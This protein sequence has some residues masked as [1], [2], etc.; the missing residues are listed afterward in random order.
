M[1]YLEKNGQD[2]VAFI[3]KVYGPDYDSGG[4]TLDAFS[5]VGRVRIAFDN[6]SVDDWSFG[7]YF[8]V[9]TVV[10]DDAEP[11][12]YNYV[13]KDKKGTVQSSGVLMVFSGPVVE[14]KEAKTI[15]QYK[16]YGSNDENN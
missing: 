16:Q 9:T 3:P 12:E 15:R 7:G 13:L 14:R 1:I 5:T 11:G 10:P 8:H 6:L 2:V 4:W